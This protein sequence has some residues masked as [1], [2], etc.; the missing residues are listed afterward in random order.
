MSALNGT[1]AIGF[2]L[3]IGANLKRILTQDPDAI[4]I[5][6]TKSGLSDEQLAQLMSWTGDHAGDVRMRFR[7]E[8][9]VSRALRS[10]IVRGCPLCLRG[11]AAGQRVPL[12]QMVMQGNWL[13]RGVDVCLQ[14]NHSLVPLWENS[15]PFNRDNIGARLQEILPKLMDGGFDQPL[16]QPSLYDFWL[17][18]RLSDHQ[19]GT[20]LADQSLFAAVTICRV[21]GAE[22]RRAE[23]LEESKRAAKAAGFEAASGGPIAITKAL[24]KLTDAGDGGQLV[25]RK[26]L[27]YLYDVLNTHYRD[28]QSFDDFRGIVLEHVLRIWPLAVGDVVLGQE[29]KTR[30]VH[31]LGTAA[32]ETGIGSRLLN[33][34]LTEAG[35]FTKEDNRPNNRKTFDAV[36]FADLL[37]EIPTRVGPR[38]MSR[39]MG[40]TLYELAALEADSVLTPRTKIK[41]ILSPWRLTDGMK[42]VKD[43][44]QSARILKADAAGW[45]P[46]QKAQ[47]RL[48]ITVSRVISAIQEGHL[49]AGKR[50]EVKDYGGIVLNVAEVERYGAILEEELPEGGLV[51]AAVFARSIGMRDRK[52]FQMLIEAGHI[53]ATQTRNLKTGRDQWKM[54]SDQIAAFRKKYVTPTILAEETGRHRNTIRAAFWNRDI[55]PFQPDGIDL[56]PIYLRKEIEP[57][58]GDLAENS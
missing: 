13:F 53:E 38:A 25:T 10:P 6:A 24:E 50:P 5:V 2:A 11:M 22:L 14:H 18:R 1:D 45:E 49:Q 37:Q 40:A 27:G 20:W 56:G 16:I 58:M 26:A 43:L 17:D 42:L 3:D 9:M 19:D 34:L 36:R 47:K 52:T 31:S 28:D 48:G 54:S 7:G 29:V 55:A 12:K 51:S 39:A 35:A 15:S 21:L 33:D 57:I 32:K 30:R 46:I 44:E 23:G 8:L 4:A 41:N